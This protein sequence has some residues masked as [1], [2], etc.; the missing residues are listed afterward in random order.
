MGDDP[1]SHDGPDHGVQP[2]AVTPAG[3]HSDAHA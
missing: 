3:Q 2:R 1:P